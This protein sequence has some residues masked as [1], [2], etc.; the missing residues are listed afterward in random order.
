VQ[1]IKKINTPWPTKDAMEQVYEKNL[2]G[3]N[4]AD[5]YSGEGSHLP[6]IVTP[7]ITVVSGFLQSFENPLTVCDLGCGDFN[8][9]KELVKYSKK[10]IAIDIVENLIERRSFRISLFGYRNS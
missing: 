5:F 6:E 9:G 8:I 3:G 1:F 7:Y 2:W 4:T 10:Y